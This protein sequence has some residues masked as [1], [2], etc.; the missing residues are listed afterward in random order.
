M[1]IFYFGYEKE[2]NPIANPST[3]VKER[4]TGYDLK[5]NTCLISTPIVRT[6]SPPHFPPKPLLWDS[7][8]SSSYTGYY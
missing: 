3:S 1:I 7:A 6:T 8:L 2:K 4:C 5:V